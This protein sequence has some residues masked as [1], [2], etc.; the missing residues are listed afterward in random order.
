MGDV[1]YCKRC[2]G[3][4]PRRPEGIVEIAIAV[5]AGPVSV[6]KKIN[7]IHLKTICIRLHLRFRTVPFCHSTKEGQSLE[8]FT[9]I[10]IYGGNHFGNN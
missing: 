6:R 3:R 9:Q 1:I 2:R 10:P 4:R 8:L 5:G 7:Y